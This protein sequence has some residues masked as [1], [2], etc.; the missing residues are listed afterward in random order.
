MFV[1][2][3]LYFTRRRP[4]F[5]HRGSL[6]KKTQ[7][8]SRKDLQL[9][10]SRKYSSLTSIEGLPVSCVCI[11]DVTKGCTRRILSARC[12]KKKLKNK[13]E[14]EEE[15]GVISPH[16]SQLTHWMCLW[17]KTV[18]N[19]VSIFRIR[20]DGGA[21][22][23]DTNQSVPPQLQHPPVAVA[24]NGD[25]VFS[26]IVIFRFH[27]VPSQRVPEARGGFDRSGFS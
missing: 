11:C 26:Q 14:E 1:F 8:V 17:L 18:V 4:L 23:S 25:R 3:F 5:F 9:T 27:V 16:F 10:A 7:H 13:K 12:I 24:L 19:Q 20:W 15:K 22:P 2:T 21:V 6:F